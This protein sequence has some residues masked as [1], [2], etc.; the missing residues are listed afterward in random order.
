MVDTITKIESKRNNYISTKNGEI[1]KKPSGWTTT[2]SIMAGTA[3]GVAITGGGICT[4]KKAKESF[5]QYATKITKHDSSKGD[6]IW[7]AIEKMHSDNADKFA[8]KDIQ[9]FNYSSE[10]EQIE[11]FN[12]IAKAKG[13]DQVHRSFSEAFDEKLAKICKNYETTTKNNAISNTLN[14]I[15][16]WRL[17]KG[18]N[19]VRKYNMP[20]PN[21]LTK[22]YYKNP[23]LAMKKS[24]AKLATILNDIQIT[25]ILLGLGNNA[26]SLNGNAYVL[27]KGSFRYSLPHELGHCLNNKSKGLSKL[28]HNLYNLPNL[29]L[30]KSSKYTIP[31]LV[32]ISLVTLFRRKKVEGEESRTLAGKSLDFVKNNCVGITAA[33]C[34]PKLIE[35]ANASI[36]GLKMMKPYLPKKEIGMLKGFYGKAYLTY[37]AIVATMTGFIWG[38]NTVKNLIDKPKKVKEEPTQE[39]ANNI[40]NLTKLDANV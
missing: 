9:W 37:L 26:Y 23:E 6:V 35:E 1:Y 28:W 14:K 32:P 17:E 8:S 34:T 20:Y 36:K 7:N 15:S 27:K 40:Q 31:L 30:S 3:T 16:K 5:E 25:D 10:Y 12:A 29:K 11:R 13:Y 2:G 18:L 19:N 39:I 33:L 38:T 4:F 24:C 21:K 22:L